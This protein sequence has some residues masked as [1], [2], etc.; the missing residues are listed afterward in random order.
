MKIKILI[1]ITIA[2]QMLTCQEKKPFMP[3]YN[4]EVSHPDNKYEI[5]PVEDKII[6]LEGNTAHLPYGGSSGNWGDSGKMFT[7][8]SGTPTGADIIYY[9]GY[10][11]VFYH[12]KADFPLEK[13]KEMVR[14]AYLNDEHDD[15]K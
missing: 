6:T 14:R 7:K 4:I 8:Q 5:E 13:L 1:L 3:I 9:A 15:C 10:E 11:D 12:L 2:F